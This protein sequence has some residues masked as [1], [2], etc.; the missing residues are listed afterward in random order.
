MDVSMNAFDASLMGI[1]KGQ[2]MAAKASDS[3]AKFGTTGNQQQLTQDL[4]QLKQSEIQVQ[5]STKAFST[6]DG[7]IGSLLDISV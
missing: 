4:I 3:I 2:Q 7:M 5:A 1:Q 6:A